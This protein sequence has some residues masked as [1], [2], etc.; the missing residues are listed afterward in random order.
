MIRDVIVALFVIPGAA[1]IV[2]AAIGAVRMPDLF[3]RMQ[4]TTKGAVLGTGL[5]LTFS[6]GM[7]LLA[8]ASRQYGYGLNLE[9][10]CRI[11]RGGCIIRAKLLERLRLAYQDR[12]DLPCLLLDHQL[13]DQVR[14]GAPA[15]REVVGLAAASGIPAP[16]LMASLAYLDA[17]RSE[18][19][20]T[21]LVQ[22][23]RD[24]F[25]GHTFERVDQTG[26]FHFDWQDQRGDA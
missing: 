6:Q 17:M 7:A 13:G 22:A 9:D 26:I 16:G 12:P 15:L 20:P 1:L 18:R 10:V 25:G 11:W 8:G 3:T 4:A 5:I 19:L 21:N 2:I 23:Q 14:S 24:F